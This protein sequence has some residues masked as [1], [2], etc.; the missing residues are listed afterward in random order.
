MNWTNE[1]E[2]A[3]YEKG[4]NILVAA[5]AGSGK[6]AVLVERI[7]N[8][9]ICENIDIDRL[10][11]VT[12]TNAAASEMRERIL[13]AIYA[14]LEEE[15][16]PNLQRQITLLNKASICTIDA[17]C[18]DVIRNNF[19][20]LDISPNFRIAN[21]AEVE[22]L[23]QEILE[24]IFEKKYIAEDEDFA[25]LIQNYSDY[26]NDEPLRNLI[27]KIY[28]FIQS[29]PYPEEWLE[30]QTEKFNIQDI[31]KDFSKT[32]WGKILLKDLEDEIVDCITILKEEAKKLSRYEELE[33]NRKVIINDIGELET[34]KQNL[35][36]W[37]K[38]YAVGENLEFI[39]WPRNKSTLELKDKAKEARDSV[40]KRINKKILQ[41]NSKE[42]NQDIK[43]MFETLTKLKNIILEFGEEFAKAKREKNILDFNDIEHLALKILV[44]KEDG[45]IKQ[46]EVAK[47]YQEKYKEIA[48][49][50]YQDSNMLQ[51]YI[52]SSISNQKNIF[53]VGD[54]KQSIY[55]FRQARPDLF[56]SKYTT[57]KLKENKKENDD[58]K[59]QLFKNF[60]SRKNVLEFTNNVFESIMA[61]NPWEIDYNQDEFLNLGAEYKQNSENLKIEIKVVDTKETQEQ[62]KE[63]QNNQE[64]L[65]EESLKNANLKPED[66]NTD[67][68]TQEI[69]EYVEDI[70][71]EANLVANQIQELLAKKFQVCDTKKQEFRDIKYKDIAILLRSTK[72]KATVYEKELEKRGIPVFTDA[73]SE[74][75]ETIEIQTIMSLLK[76]I[77][78]PLQ[79]IPLV[80][81]L[82]SNIGGFTDDDL[83]KIRL[84][85]KFD[86][87]YNTLLKA[88]INSEGT[89]RNKIDLF[90]DSLEEWRQEKEYL[91]LDEL[92]WKIYVDTGYYNYVGLMPNGLQRQANL[93]ILFERAKEYEKASFKGL[94]NFIGFIEKIHTGSGDLSSA[95][96]IGENED[97]VRIMSI[98]KSKG[99]EF[100]VVF[101]VNTAQQFNQQDIK[102]NI[103]LHSDLGIG[104]KYID[105]DKKIEFDTL[106]KKAIANKLLLENLSE[107][108]RILYVALTRA[109]E[110][111]YI[112]GRINGTEK[113]L[114]DIESSVERYPKL[115]NKIN[116]ILIKKCK[117]YLDWL[118]TV[119]TYNKKELEEICSLEI[120]PKNKVL[121]N[122][123]TKNEKV[124]VIEK[125]NSIESKKDKYEEVRKILEFEYKNKILSTIPT[126]TSVSK[127][128]IQEEELDI[129]FSK[130]KFLSEDEQETISAA[131]KGTLVHLCMQKLDNRKEYT[132]QGIVELIEHLKNQKIITQKEAESINV[133]KIYQFTLSPIYKRIKNAKQIYK[134]KPFYI[135]IPISELYD[136]DVDGK[137]LVQGI[138]DM[139]FIDEDDKLVL[140]DYKTDYVEIG[141]EDKLIEKYRVQLELYQRAL[142]DALGRK[143]DEKYIYST[144][145]N[146]LLQFG[147]KSLN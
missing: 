112:T 107:E 2:Q 51:E 89:L 64:T 6:T 122:E 15:E 46:T 141:K 39:K 78:N 111:L 12:F 66:Y 137:I 73:S 108:M 140:L 59:I 110:K 29:N 116:P 16:N 79:D 35:D 69:E 28:T 70:E 13:K 77:D 20:E 60:R 95:K 139:Y 120:L 114:G 117:S 134:E 63:E 135:N 93:K 56:Y 136:E 146:K 54:I 125:L 82:R 105:Y 99:L 97:V 127:I 91:A 17:F 74:Y 118:L 24:D 61:E 115:Q 84:S 38:A 48:I 45:K 44:K 7:I 40:K 8:K 36:T 49:D 76:I 65:Q 32:E 92:I 98:H 4:N 1:Q 129:S 144:G 88:R 71:I 23:K 100:P 80:A 75:L 9:I 145:L 138:I 83:I 109:K 31:E 30:E 123:I 104:V 37:D 27:L 10:L 113:K 25:K 5:A 33:E 128:K 62:F 96:I 58:L 132:K 81:V 142:E 119:Y 3:I 102:E 87:F 42:A 67:D 57:Y 53:M 72:I 124:D 133:Q 143:V 52:L 121:K 68:E 147:E 18:L 34:F 101:L 90:L 103:L 126:K 94:F 86:N 43:D 106:S 41:C 130:P 50:E 131:Q 11:V 26:R 21:T 55:K 47:K 22:L 19:F 85:D 14:K